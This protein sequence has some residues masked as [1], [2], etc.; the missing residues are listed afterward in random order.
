MSAALISIGVNDYLF[1]ASG[2]DS[3]IR[4]LKDRK[5]QHHYSCRLSTS[6]GD[7]I[8]FMALSCQNTGLFQSFMAYYAK[9]DF[10]FFCA[11][12]EQVGIYFIE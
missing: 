1:M 12:H 7:K 11:C 9:T 2:G 6:M 8:N 4:Q 3:E 5:C 10:F